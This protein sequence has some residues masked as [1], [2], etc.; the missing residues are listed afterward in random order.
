ME[1]LAGI[2][3]VVVAII[4]KVIEAKFKKAS[5]NKSSEV[6]PREVFPELQ[7][8]PKLPEQE[9]VIQTPVAQAPVEVKKVEVNPKKKAPVKQPRKP[10][11]ETEEKKTREKIDP[12]KLIVY[13]EIMNRK[14]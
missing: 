8:L 6:V 12:K 14:Y 7:E 1:E 5:K 4:M 9:P 3:F 10:I 11:L 13:S 2:L